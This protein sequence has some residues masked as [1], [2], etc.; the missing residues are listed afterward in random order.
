[1]DLRTWITEDHAALWPRYAD[2]IAGIVPTARWKEHADGGG[3]CIAQ[4]LFHVS[5]HADMALHCVL[6]AQPPLVD[7]WRERLGLASIEPHRGLA[8]SED[9]GVVAAVAPAELHEYAAAVHSA[10]AHWLRAADLAALDEVPDSSARLVSFGGVSVDAVPWL[11]R[12]WDG[13]PGSWFVQWECTGHILNHIG[14][15]VSVR[16]RMGLS[17]F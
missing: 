4:L 15:M 7:T 8:E 16:N 5:L 13:R 9:P 14:E 10:T 6:Q 17:P 12:M 3:S 1:M 2:S 11:H